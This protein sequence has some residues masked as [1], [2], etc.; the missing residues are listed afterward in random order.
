M[1]RDIESD[2]ELW[3]DDPSRKPLLLRGARQV[4]KTFVVRQFAEAFPHF[5]EIN[6][7]RRPELCKIFESLDPKKILT[8]LNIEF[9]NKITPGQS[10][11]F[12]DEIQDC[13]RAIMAL[14]YFKE[15]LPEL[16]VIGAG[17]LLEFTL[18]DDNFK[19]PVGRVQFLHIYPFS[20]REFLTASGL[21]HL[22][23]YLQ[24][25]TAHCTIDEPIHKKLMQ[26]VRKYMILGGMP[27]V[28]EDYLKT[29]DIQR[30]EHVQTDLLATYRSDFGKYASQTQHKY[31]QI[32]FE[33]A[34][35]L[36]AQ[37]FKYS[38]IDPNIQSRELKTALS[39][40]MDAGL[41]HLIYASAAQGLPL[42]SSVNLKKF[43][44]IFLD[45]GLA[46][47]AMGMDIKSLMSEDL[48]LVNRGAI[49]EQ[50][51]GQELLTLVNP[52]ELRRLYFW[53]RDARGSSAEVD[54]LAN[55]GSQIVPIEV[56]SGATGRLRS[57]QIFMEEKK[58]PL[59]VRISQSP[60]SLD[61]N[62]LSIPFYMI[63]E[64]PRLTEELE[65]GR[66]KD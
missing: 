55:I 6:F 35:G 5:A 20:F 17:S 49:S 59:G 16:H 12:L 41:I 48:M 23:E 65:F 44:L 42:V 58:I 24:T 60:L 32:L 9:S 27:A 51:V 38:K 29:E 8:L 50:L 31:L 19:M 13:P 15:E 18:N 22:R 37:W 1:K 4:G 66:H 52:R 33:R 45:V 26:L 36:I 39:L 63:A 40:L 47:R 2:L 53:V 46:H 54:Y 61:K 56:K 62:I 11:L 43:K 7:E 21:Q 25:V 64:L 14:R 57:L 3:K 10:L 28:L 30:S 34:P